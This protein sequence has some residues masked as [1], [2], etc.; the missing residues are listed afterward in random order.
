MQ[1]AAQAF[2]ASCPGRRMG[3]TDQCRS[4]SRR[5]WSDQ[6]PLGSSPES[7][8]GCPGRGA[9]AA[10]HAER[11]EWAAAP[12]HRPQAVAAAAARASPAPQLPARSGPD[13]LLRCP[14]HRWCRSGA[15]AAAADSPAA[16][17]ARAPPESPAQHRQGGNPKRGASPLPP[18]ERHCSLAA[19]EAA[20]PAAAP[21]SRR[22]AKVVR[23]PGRGPERQRE[24][25]ARP[26][27]VTLRLR[28]QPAELRQRETPRE[29]MRPVEPERPVPEARSVELAL[30]LR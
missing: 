16:T 17:S 24:S 23:Q 4:A 26:R 12:R 30:R 10:A 22:L 6:L 19:A 9:A 18:Q 5:P 25:A 8:P 27:T 7:A 20:L 1:K 13:W 21:V 29:R 3:Q 14:C 28:E 11:W 15:A 2:L